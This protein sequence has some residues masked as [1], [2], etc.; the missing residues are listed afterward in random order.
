MVRFR[1]SHFVILENSM[2]IP[3]Y[4]TSWVNFDQNNPNAAEK[5]GTWA[6]AWGVE[7]R[8]DFV[9]RVNSKHIAR[10]NTENRMAAAGAYS[11]LA[12]IICFVIVACII[13]PQILQIFSALFFP[14]TCNTKSLSAL[15]K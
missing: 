9:H 3:D 1:L 15:R 13:V 7:D 5:K 4:D 10:Y 8:R 14:C 6:K 11:T 2:F 12:V